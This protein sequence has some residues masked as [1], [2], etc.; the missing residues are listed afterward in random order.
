MIQALLKVLHPDTGVAPGWKPGVND[1]VRMSKALENWDSRKQKAT[2][3]GR[4]SFSQL[5]FPVIA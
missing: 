5:S 3:G 2:N 4:L 1:T